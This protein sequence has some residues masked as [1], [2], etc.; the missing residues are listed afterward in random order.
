MLIALGCVAACVAA[1][2]CGKELVELAAA[3]GFL[4][5]SSIQDPTARA[6]LS[7]LPGVLFAYGGLVFPLTYLVRVF[8]PYIR[9]GARP[10][11]ERSPL[12]I[13]LFVAIMFVAGIV[14]AA[15][16]FGFGLLTEGQ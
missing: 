3:G 14:V 2:W 6:V 15:I 13:G 5:L 12:P 10:K 11:T 7:Y 9:R 1:I 8:S 16:V 4:N